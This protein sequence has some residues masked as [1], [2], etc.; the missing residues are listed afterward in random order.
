[1]KEQAKFL[2]CEGFLS[3]FSQTYPKKKLHKKWPPKRKLFMLFWAP[4]L[5]IFSGVSSEF[6]GFC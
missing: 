6:Q 3:E 4:L 1:V 5:L 2:G